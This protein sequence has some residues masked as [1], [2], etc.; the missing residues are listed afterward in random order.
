[1]SLLWAAAHSK[2][3][4]LSVQF[5]RLAVRRGSKRA[6]LAVAHTILVVAYHLLS[7]HCE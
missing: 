5:K 3:T 4:Y 2:D 6:L 1:M 7:R